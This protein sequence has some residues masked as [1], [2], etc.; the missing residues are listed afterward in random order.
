MELYIIKDEH[1]PDWQNYEVYDRSIGRVVLQTGDW[2]K[3]VEFLGSNIPE[4]Q[5]VMV[6]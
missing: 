6:D 4:A 5:I 3:V 2:L 1:A